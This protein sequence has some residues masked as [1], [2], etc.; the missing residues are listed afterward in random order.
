MLY[1]RFLLQNGFFRLKKR[2]CSIAQGNDDGQYDSLERH[3]HINKSRCGRRLSTEETTLDEERSGTKNKHEI[4]SLTRMLMEMAT[5]NRAKMTQVQKLLT[6]ASSEQN[7]VKSGATKTSIDTEPKYSPSQLSQDAVTFGCPNRISFS[8]TDKDVL[9]QQMEE[10]GEMCKKDLTHPVSETKT[11]LGELLTD[12]DSSIVQ[13]GEDLMKQRRKFL[14]NRYKT[15]TTSKELDVA[16]PPLD[17]ISII[18]T[19]DSVCTTSV[20]CFAGLDAHSLQ[21]SLNVFWKQE[22]NLSKTPRIPNVLSAFDVEIEFDENGNEIS[23]EHGHYANVFL[24]KM[25]SGEIPGIQYVAIK[26]YPKPNLYIGW[27]DILKEASTYKTL[28]DTNT[29]PKFVGLVC[30]EPQNDYWPI[31]IVCQYVGLRKSS[32]KFED[33]SKWNTLTSLLAKQYECTKVSLKMGKTEWIR[34]CIELC[35]KLWSVH[36]RHIKLVYLNPD[37]VLV[38]K[39]GNKWT[40]YFTGLSNAIC[41]QYEPPGLKLHMQAVPPWCLKCIGRS[42]KERRYYNAYKDS[43]QY[44]MFRTHGMDINCLGQI[45]EAIADCT[46]INFGRL[47]FQCKQINPSARPSLPYIIEQLAELGDKYQQEEKWH[48]NSEGPCS[49]IFS[50]KMALP[51]F[52]RKGITS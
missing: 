41:Y 24:G 17:E 8:D 50:W 10:N 21:R 47:G 15:V 36:S 38:E 2:D 5:S 22:A 39:T 35:E 12:S 19:R 1:C 20:P 3:P 33:D 18:K 4:K 16:W 49:R 26:L 31:G 52:C 51:G 7:S 23:V 9:Q 44:G 11:Q 25:T 14:M 48:R 6:S 13:W 46:G 29:V 30:L 43:D 27:L 28:Q 40:P 32:P 37:T 42:Q 45:F 34:F